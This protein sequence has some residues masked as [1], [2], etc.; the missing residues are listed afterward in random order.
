MTLKLLNKKLN[1]NPALRISVFEFFEHIWLFNIEVLTV[2]RNRGIGS[3]AIRELQDY[4]RSVGKPIGLIPLAEPRCKQKLER[5]Y[6]RLG[7][8]WT[9]AKTMMI[10]RAE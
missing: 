10:W 5:F 9:R 3:S 2:A 4:A 7:F 6:H 1:A 8:K